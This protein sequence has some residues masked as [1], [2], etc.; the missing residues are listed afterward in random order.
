VVCSY[1]A[2]LILFSLKKEGNSNTCYNMDKSWGYEPEWNKSVTKKIN[3]IWF[4]SHKV[5]RVV[6]FIHSKMVV[7]RV[8]GGRE[9]GA[10]VLSL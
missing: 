2:V 5:S 10:T 3:I 9:W 7:V 6:K 1:D 4:Y 8:W